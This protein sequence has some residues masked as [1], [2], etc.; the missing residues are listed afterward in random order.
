MY[1]SMSKEM[2]R[3]KLSVKRAVAAQS[4]IVVDNNKKFYLNS[5]AIINLSLQTID[6]KSFGAAYAY[7]W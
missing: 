1:D 3:G 4:L 5:D 7:G 6:E 2:L